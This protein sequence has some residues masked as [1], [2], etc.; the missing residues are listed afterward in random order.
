MSLS[1]SI[2]CCSAINK[3]KLIFK[4]WQIDTFFHYFLFAL[5]YYI[6]ALQS[7]HNFQKNILNVN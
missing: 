2:S 5:C 6:C 4:N 1:F 7:P 3:F